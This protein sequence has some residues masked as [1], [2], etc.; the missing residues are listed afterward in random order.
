MLKQHGAVV[1][2]KKASGKTRSKDDGQKSLV[3]IPTVNRKVAG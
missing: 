3:S 1:D 2:G